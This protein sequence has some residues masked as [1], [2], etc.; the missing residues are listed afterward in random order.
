MTRRILVEARGRRRVPHIIYADRCLA[1]PSGFSRRP[2]II[3]RPGS[4]L[5]ATQVGEMLGYL[6]RRRTRL[7]KSIRHLPTERIGIA[8]SPRE[9][10]NDG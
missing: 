5:T 10:G 2:C 8:K 7:G 1:L 4:D 9:R 6:V 3:G